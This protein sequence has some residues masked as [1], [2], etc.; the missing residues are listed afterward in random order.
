MKTEEKN[1]RPV[2]GQAGKQLRALNAVVVLIL[3]MTLWSCAHHDNDPQKERIAAL[4]DKVWAYSQSH[5]DGF[6]LD[7]C[8]MT[9]P[10][11]G[12]AVSYAAT[13]NSHSS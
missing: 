12:I 2:T 7:V 11:E 10:Q 4:A 5:P 8:T 3:A 6:T 9:E 13:Q 1:R